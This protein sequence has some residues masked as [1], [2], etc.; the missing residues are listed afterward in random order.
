MVDSEYHKENNKCSKISIR[1]VM[2]QKLEQKSRN[3]N[4]LKT[5]KLRNHGVKKNTFCNK[6]CS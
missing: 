6:I 1:T 4:H 2:E 5:K 3:L